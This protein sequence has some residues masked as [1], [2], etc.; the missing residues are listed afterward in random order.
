MKCFLVAPNSLDVSTITECLNDLGVEQLSP[1]IGKNLD[2]EVSEAIKDAD[3][4]IATLSS[5]AR[6]EDALFELGAAYG[7]GKQIII[8]CTPAQKLPYTLRSFHVIR[9][10]LK[11]SNAIKF[12]LSQ[13]LRSRD[14]FTSYRNSNL[15][16]TSFRE[17][18]Y[19]KHIQALR[20]RVLHDNASRLEVE[21]ADA[22]KNSGLEVIQSE[23][24]LDDNFVP[25]ILVWL[26]LANA[27]Q[28]EPVMVEIKNNLPRLKSQ[29]G[30]KLINQLTKYLQ[31]SNL[32]T[33]L[34]ISPD[35]E[36]PSVILGS[37]IIAVLNSN[38]VLDSLAR[39]NLSELLRN[40]I[41][42]QIRADKNAD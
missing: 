1:K 10:S 20:N 18:A 2:A 5:N 15:Q 36:K 31:R 29:Q 12:H 22:F 28:S 34:L 8:F 3:F 40:L 25:D 6:S 26:N 27:N 33:A 4:I 32:K 14:N 16:D 39:G 11:D 38:K 37:S 9:T 23:F 21:I 17:D 13:F 19:V 30:K 35:V 24:A 7:L 42:K 41:A